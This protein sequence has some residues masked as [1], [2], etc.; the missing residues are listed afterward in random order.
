MRTERLMSS[1]FAEFYEE[2]AR[3]KQAVAGGRLASYL[4]GKNSG[5]DLA[6]STGARLLALLATQEQR[7]GASANH[8]EL[9]AYGLARYFMAALADEIL[10][11]NL[12]WE[13]SDYWNDHLIERA[14]FQRAVA[15]RDFY[16]LADRVLHSR[17]NNPVMADLAAVALMCMQL[18]FQG[19]YRGKTGAEARERYRKKLLHF[20]GVGADVHS[21]GGNSKPLFPS[22]YAGLISETTE[23]RLAPFSRWYL[24]GL[25]VVFMYLILSTGVWVY[26]IRDL[27][28]VVPYQGVFDLFTP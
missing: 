26:N 7:V 13:G 3:I 5:P 22:A 17:G 25:G 6:A 11:V 19:Q 14:L 15:G 12:N 28:S 16:L 10:G 18:G 23:S 2:L 20:I 27:T 21:A 8:M 24:L 9:K 4:G 1:C